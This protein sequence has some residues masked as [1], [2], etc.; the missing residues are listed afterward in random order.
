[1]GYFEHFGPNSP[2]QSARLRSFA[3]T[4]TIAC[5]FRLGVELSSDQMLPRVADFLRS[6]EKQDAADLLAGTEFF[7][8]E[9]QKFS[10][11]ELVEICMVFAAR[12][13]WADLRKTASGLE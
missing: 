2:V 13:G 10:E 9:I 7:C 1:M 4:F 12:C 6:L 8:G 11:V 3:I 5:P